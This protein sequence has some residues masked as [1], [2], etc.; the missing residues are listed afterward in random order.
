MFETIHTFTVTGL[1]A[2]SFTQANY[3][4]TELVYFHVTSHKTKTSTIFGHKDVQLNVT[5]WSPKSPSF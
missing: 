2:Q 5:F 1:A 3:S 4:F